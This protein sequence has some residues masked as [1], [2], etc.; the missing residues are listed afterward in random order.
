MELLD[1]LDT[2]EISDIIANSSM[3]MNDEF[4]KIGKKIKDFDTIIYHAACPDGIGGLW[5]GCHYSRSS[6]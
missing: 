3:N 1:T 2:V 6:D 4:D 5:C